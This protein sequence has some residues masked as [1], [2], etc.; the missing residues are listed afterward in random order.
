MQWPM[1]CILKRFYE[2]LPK[3][4][5]SNKLLL[6]TP[7]VKQGLLIWIKYLEYLNGVTFNSLLHIPTITEELKT[8]ASDMGYGGIKLPH[9]FFGT[10]TANMRKHNENENNIDFAEM[11]G[12]AVGIS[13]FASYFLGKVVI[14]KMDNQGCV[15]ALVKK[16]A[17]K[18]TTSRIIEFIY[19]KAMKYKFVF[20]VEWVQREHNILAD[21][22]SKGKINKFKQIC[23]NNKIIIDPNSTNYEL[24]KLNI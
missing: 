21:L 19:F 7:T 17:K 16:S 23:N 18:S 24:P 3:D 5:A 10:F 14:I 9:W 1:K 2:V 12:A 6:V 20:F 4:S 15:D 22:L 8:D 13:A 11:Y